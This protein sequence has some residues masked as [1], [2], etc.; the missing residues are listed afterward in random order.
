M[1]ALMEND[2]N[3]PSASDN[4]GKK[5]KRI[6]SVSLAAAGLLASATSALGS[7]VSTPI[8]KAKTTVEVSAQQTGRNIP[9]PL[10]LKLANSNQQ[11]AFDHE[12]HAS[13]SSHASHASHASHSS[14]L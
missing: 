2:K 1:E 12:S 7:I 13:H 10:V 6:L 11:L 5:A 14:G 4:T 9:A 8:E 3:G